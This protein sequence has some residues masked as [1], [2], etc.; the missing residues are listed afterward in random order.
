MVEL[1]FCLYIR[2]NVNSK[3]HCINGDVSSPGERCNA[4]YCSER[5]LP[6]ILPLVLLCTVHHPS[7]Q[8][9]HFFP[10]GQGCCAPGSFVLIQPSTQLHWVALSRFQRVWSFGLKV[11]L[12]KTI[13]ETP[14][15]T[16]WLFSDCDS[17]TIFCSH[18]HFL[19]GSYSFFI[20]I[21]HMHILDNLSRT[22]MLMDGFDNFFSE[23]KFE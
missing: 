5:H 11:S 2:I 13:R 21:T 3:R 12:S 18:A 1:Y 9:F 14:R 4:L 16:Q 17:K 8:V 23:F 15:S 22:C 6:S 20:L 19:Q 7:D 10:K